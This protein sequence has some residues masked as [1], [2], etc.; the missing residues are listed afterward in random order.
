MKTH[1][2]H[3]LTNIGARNRVELASLAWATESEGA[4]VRLLPHPGRVNREAV[5]LIHQVTL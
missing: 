2:S 4:E 5:C 3:L 1:R